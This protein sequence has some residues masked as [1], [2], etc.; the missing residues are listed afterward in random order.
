MEKFEYKLFECSTNWSTEETND[1]LVFEAYEAPDWIDVNH[2][3]SDGW[4]LIGFIPGGHKWIH[5]GLTGENDELGPLTSTEKARYR[6]F[7]QIGVFKRK[8]QAA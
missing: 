5:P 1:E 7:S 4:E 3:G 2:L 6:E 8:T